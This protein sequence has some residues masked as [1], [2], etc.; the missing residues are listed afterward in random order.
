[1]TKLIAITSIRAGTGKTTIA[2]ILAEKLCK[3]G[4]VLIIDNNKLN[5]NIYNIK[6]SS[7]DDIKLYLC[8]ENK[9]TCKKAIKESATEIKDN[10]FFFSGSH[11]LLSEKELICLKEQNIFDYIIVDTALLYNEFYDFSIMIINPNVHEYIE[12]HK[13][14]LANSILLVNK[15]INEIEFK[16]SKDHFKLYFCSEIIN[17]TNGY[18]LVLPEEN[19]KEIETL[20]MKIT[21]EELKNEKSKFRLFK[22][23]KS[24]GI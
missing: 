16:I 2:S 9:E 4:T 1:M 7:I 3:E 15:F 22:R 8:L 12:F 24:N 19:K 14:K 13:L 6:T 11:E 5:I 10:I 18:E 21:G 23:R 20:L 17:F